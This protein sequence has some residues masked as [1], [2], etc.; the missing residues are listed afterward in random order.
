MA[1]EKKDISQVPSAQRTAFQKASDASRKGNLDY[2]ISLL[3]N[4]VIANP[5][6]MDARAKLRE[7]ERAL[8]APGL[9]TQIINKFKAGKHVVSGQIKMGKDARAAMGA[10]EDALALGLKNCGALKLLA[11]AA[12]KE[13]APFIAV[14]ALEMAN[15]FSPN[16]LGLMEMLVVAYRANRQGNDALRVRQQ[17]ANLQPG[18]LEAQAAV[19]EAAAAATM[20]KNWEGNTK[21]SDSLKDKG[22]T[23]AAEQADRIV[24]GADDIRDM[25]KRLEERFVKEPKNVEVARKLGEYCQKDAQHD[26]AIEWFNKASELIG[27]LDPTIDRLIEKSELAK[28]DQSIEQ[29]RE[30]G[31]TNPG[32][33]D[34][35]EQNIAAFEAQKYQLRLERATS[36]VNSYPSDLQLRFDL[37]LVQWEGQDYDHAIEQFQLAQKNPQRRLTVLVYLGRCFY[38][39]QQYDIAVEQFD[40][41][42]ADMLAMDKHKLEALY[43]L[44]LTHEAMGAMDKAMECFKTIYQADSKFKDVGAKVQNFY[45]QQK[46]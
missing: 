24:R 36:R 35:A 16:D 23:A 13:D 25:I 18:S 44:G 8:P 26:K 15:D 27:S 41:A 7:L 3:K 19:R 22:E 9:V 21:F 30:Y 46:R 2:A 17:M 10:A 6:F 28:F 37:G 39:K 11:A 45:A 4:I 43:Y 32:S 29:W 1:I 14:E 42:I 38:S 12:A 33:V 31:E 40:R 5:G 20:E 34:E